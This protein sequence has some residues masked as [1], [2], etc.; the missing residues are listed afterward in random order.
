[1]STDRLITNTRHKYTSFKVY[2][3]REKCPNTDQKIL[4]IWTL[5]TQ[6]YISE[7]FLDVYLSIFYPAVFILN[8]FSRYWDIWYFLKDQM[9]MYISS[10]LKHQ[11][12]LWQSHS[13]LL[14]PLWTCL[15]I[16]SLFLLELP[17]NLLVT[18]MSLS[19]SYVF[20]LDSISSLICR[21]N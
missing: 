17:T 16:I 10:L 14:K 7:L 8:I 13:P 9:C 2:T 1:M 19:S 5:F 4:R 18:R 12:Q 21:V 3:L 6:C 11:R 15:I 20:K